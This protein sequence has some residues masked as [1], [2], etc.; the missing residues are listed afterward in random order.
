MAHTGTLM[1][2]AKGKQ[3]FVC[4]CEGDTD[5]TRKKVRCLWTDHAL[6]TH[7]HLSWYTQDSSPQ[8]LLVL[9]RD[10]LNLGDTPGDRMQLRCAC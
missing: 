9:P 2:P 6:H 10:T 7:H 4:T 1:T 5:R 8:L 3:S